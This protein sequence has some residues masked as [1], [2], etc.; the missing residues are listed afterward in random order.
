M[1]DGNHWSRLVAPQYA[2]RRFIVVAES[3]VAA[4]A[5][6]EFLID[7][8][9]LRPL[10]I[11]MARGLGDVPSD[12]QAEVFTLGLDLPPDAGAR[13]MPF[14]RA[15]EAVM[16]DPPPEILEWLDVWDPERDARVLAP[17]LLA[18]SAMGGRAVYGGRRAEWIALEDKMIV[19]QFWDEVGVRRAPSRILPLDH[20]LL[21][22]AAVDLDWGRGTV[23]VGDNREGWHGGAEYLQWVRN[24]ADAGDAYRFFHQHCD[25]V[26]VM[27]FLEGTPCSIHGIV[28]DATVIA[29]RPFEMLVL[30]VEGTP[31]LKYVGTA[32]F[33][34]PPDAD[35]NEMRGVARRVG[36][37]LAV[38]A[39]FR[40]MFTVDGVMTVAGFLPTELNPRGGAGLGRAVRD[41]EGLSLLAVQR[42]L[43]EG[44]DLDYRPAD[45]ET[46]IVDFADANRYGAAFF[47][48]PEV[49]EMPVEVTLKAT[50]DQV[51]AVAEG[52]VGNLTL[53]WG[54]GTVGGAVAIR[55][56]PG[57]VPAGESVAGLTAA[58]LKYARRNWPITMPGL[59]TI[60]EAQ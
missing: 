18:G 2:G 33:W 20:E 24:P 50:A 41:L 19:D 30:A 11:A 34:D 23:W 8:G 59:V 14:M 53:T 1:M 37:H 48:V 17:H 3:L 7:H 42:A 6:V 5:Q 29:A 4:K 40:G 49:P 46:L 16:S 31:G 55:F 10:V 58:A 28:F 13:L 12:D 36:H 44:F 54:G 47:Q 9:A 27:P 26:R 43:I 21:A 52:E 39:D 45:L 57:A 60:E 32:S 38:I 35:R 56:M 22:T 15:V 25:R 51:V